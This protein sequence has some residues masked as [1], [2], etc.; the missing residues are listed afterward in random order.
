MVDVLLLAL[1]ML[2]MISINAFFYRSNEKNTT[3]I[4]D[5]ISQKENSVLWNFLKDNDKPVRLKS[6]AGTAS[7]QTNLILT[8]ARKYMDGGE[9]DKALEACNNA[10]IADSTDEECY[11]LTAKINTLLNKDIDAISDYSKTLQ[12]NPRHYQAYLNRGIL[13]LK[14]KKTAAAYYD[15]LNAIKINPLKTVSFLFSHALHSIF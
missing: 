5:S 4:A 11:F 14:I 10:I 1:T 7:Y 13:Q 2:L 12:L 8:K 9:L 15:F 3:S 6:T